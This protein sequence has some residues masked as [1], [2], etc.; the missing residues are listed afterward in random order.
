MSIS[1]YFTFRNKVNR[2]SKPDQFI[3]NLICKKM[4]MLKIYFNFLFVV[5]LVGD[6]W[7]SSPRYK[8]SYLSGD[9]L[10]YVMFKLLETLKKIA[11]SV[12]IFV[13]TEY[14]QRNFE[15]RRHFSDLRSDKDLM[16]IYLLSY[17]FIKMETKKCGVKVFITGILQSVRHH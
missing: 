12:L 17:G 7:D 4:K 16:C 1:N 15:T 11:S 5:S 14:T 9:G 3:D 8:D 10:G 2:C 13:G 6:R